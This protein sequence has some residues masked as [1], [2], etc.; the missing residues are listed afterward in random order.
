M[1]DLNYQLKLLCRRNRD[2]GYLTRYN[3]ER[4]LTL[5]A[6][7]L[8]EMGFHHMVARSLKPKHVEALVKRWQA[9]GIALGTIKNRMSALRWWAEK[10]DKR[11]V[12]ARSNA[13]YGIGRRS[14]ITDGSSALELDPKDLGRIGDAH[15]RLSVELQR[16]F[17]L[18][19]EEA[20]KFSPR[21]ADRGDR[22]G[23]KASWTKGGKA[24][25]IPVRTVAQRDLL[26]RVHELVGSGALIPP[27]RNYR[28]QRLVYERE[29]AKAGLR[30]LHRLRHAYAQERY[31]DLTGWKPPAAGGPPSRSLSAERQRRDRGARLAISREL[32]H[33]R[34]E[35]TGIYLNAQRSAVS[36]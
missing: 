12:M 11:N 30:K 4:I 10:V 35:I 33:E 32:G 1:I 23:L 6:N 27:Q 5:I 20:I 25:N 36:P 14:Y 16:A 21:A 17:G 22:I 9:E 24:R 18:R 29:T 3:R 13:H 31:E 15:V 8:H 28:E 19:R 7:Q 26:D 2:G 34:G